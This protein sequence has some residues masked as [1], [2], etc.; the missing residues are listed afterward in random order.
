MNRGGVESSKRASVESILLDVIL[1]NVC[2]HIH[3]QGWFSDYLWWKPKGQ[4]SSFLPKGLKEFDGFEPDGGVWGK[5]GCVIPVIV[6]EAKQG[7]QGGQADT[8]LGYKNIFNFLSN[9]GKRGINPEGRYIII[10][11][12][13]G[14]QSNPNAKTKKD[15]ANLRS[16]LLNYIISP[17]SG[18]L[19]E[20]KKNSPYG[21]VGDL[22]VDVDK[23]GELVQLLKQGNAFGK[24]KDD[25]STILTFDDM[26]MLDKLVEYTRTTASSGADAGS[27][28]AGAQIIGNLFTLDPGKFVDGLARLHAQGRIARLFTNKRFVQAVTGTGKPLSKAEKLRQMFFGKGALGNIIASFSLTTAQSLDDQTEELLNNQDIAPSVSRFYSN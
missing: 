18:V 7:G 8:D 13:K 1:G 23:F 20:I 17:K 22:E 2:N 6:F 9:E 15:K 12:G 28:L 21:D 25:V 19:R 16:G 26:E 4:C 10:G 3:I 27:A 5:V 11:Q 14:C 24:N